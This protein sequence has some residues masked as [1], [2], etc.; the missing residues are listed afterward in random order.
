MRAAIGHLWGGATAA[1]IGAGSVNTF[2][3][4]AK[5]KTHTVGLP[6]HAAA[7]AAAAAAALILHNESGRTAAGTNRA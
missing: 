3:N 4:R 5:E 6:R 1:V 7:A 2:I